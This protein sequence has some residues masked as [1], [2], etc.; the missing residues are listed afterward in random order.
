MP[1]DPAQFGFEHA[2]C[3][4]RQI[5]SERIAAHQFGQL[6]SPVGRGG[7]LWAHFV[8]MNRQAAPRDLP[9]GL[10]PGQ[11]AA[12]NLNGLCCCLIVHVSS[13]CCFINYT[14]FNSKRPTPPASIRPGDS[15]QNL[16]CA[17]LTRDLPF[18]YAV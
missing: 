3:P 13:P 10:G 9:C 7:F 15:C 14:A 18:W 1:S 12:N 4:I 11:P 6:A 2:R 17:L 16:T 8:E 5:R